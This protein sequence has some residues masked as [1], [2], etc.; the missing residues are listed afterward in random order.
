MSDYVIYFSLKDFVFV[1]MDL[2]DFNDPNIIFVKV[3][4]RDKGDIWVNKQL[5]LFI[6]NKDFVSL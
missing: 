5:V 1:T 4:T 2:K 6:A 3:S